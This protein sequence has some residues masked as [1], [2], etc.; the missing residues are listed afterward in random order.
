ML[1]KQG[2][3][4]AAANSPQ[5]NLDLSGLATELYGCPCLHSQL[6]AHCPHAVHPLTHP[7]DCM[8]CRT[9]SPLHWKGVQEINNALWNCFKSVRF[10]WGPGVSTL[11]R[12]PDVLQLSHSL[13]KFSTGKQSQWTST[14]NLQPGGK[15]GVFWLCLAARMQGRTLQL[16]AQQP[17]IGVTSVY[18][19]LCAKI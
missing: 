9:Q 11:L 8:L 14:C 1:I 13:G 19:G 12:L 2:Q 18:S 5:S 10:L 15:V 17:Q 6:T 7:C 16:S 3:T 4:S